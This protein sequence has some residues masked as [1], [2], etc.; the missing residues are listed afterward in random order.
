MYNIN[1]ILTKTNR[2]AKQKL[3]LIKSLIVVAEIKQKEHIKTYILHIIYKSI[4]ETAPAINN[5][6]FSGKFKKKTTKLSNL[7]LSS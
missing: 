7:R 6:L 3:V 1:Y 2:K 4:L 5:I